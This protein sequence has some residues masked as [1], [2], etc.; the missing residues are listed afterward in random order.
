METAAE[1]QI[2]QD[3]ARLATFIVDEAIPSSPDCDDPD[4]RLPAQP[5]PATHV[6][7]LDQGPSISQSSLQAIVD[8]RTR[9]EIL[10]LLDSAPHTAAWFISGSSVGCAHWLQA[11]S[12]ASR[13][14]RLFLG[15][16]VT[17]LRQRLLLPASNLSN[18]AIRAVC[19]CGVALIEDPHDQRPHCLSCSKLAPMWLRRHNELRDILYSFLDKILPSN[20]RHLQLECPLEANESNAHRTADIC[21][22]VG[23]EYYY[24]DVSVV[25][26]TRTRYHGRPAGSAAL[27]RER[28]KLAHIMA[29][30]GPSIQPAQIIPFVIEATGRLG[31]KARDFIDML[32]GISRIIP[33]PDDHLAACRRSL[34]RSLSC[35]SAKWFSL[36]SDQHQ[37]LITLTTN[38]ASA[39]TPHPPI[40]AGGALDIPTPPPTPTSFRI[41]STTWTAPTAPS[42]VPSAASTRNLSFQPRSVSRK[43]SQTYTSPPPVYSRTT[44]SRYAY[45]QLSFNNTSID[46]WGGHALRRS[47]GRPSGVPRSEV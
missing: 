17:V 33:V 5:V 23:P 28:D 15:H 12:S 43:P 32:S 1:P 39:N 38:P 30:V 29:G 4:T 40:P 24:L 14:T 45:N 3:R 26:P 11:A 47:R 6:E 31:E 25:D 9:D 18:A 16:F 34:L 20:N 42:H 21:V 35:C 13:H 41:P 2:A 8:K 7:D 44:S 46:S 36:I 19:T 22:R 37:K 10:Q 27:E